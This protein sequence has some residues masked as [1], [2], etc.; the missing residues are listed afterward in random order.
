MLPAYQGNRSAA[1]ELSLEG[2]PVYEKLDEFMKSRDKW[3]GTA[4]AL[5]KELTELASEKLKESDV[6]PKTPKALSNALR[7]LANGMRTMGID[8]DF[9]R[10][11]G[12]KRTRL[13]KIENTHKS[14]SQTSHASQTP[15][16][17]DSE[18]DASGTI[19]TVQGRS[20]DGMP[21]EN[22]EKN[23]IGDDGDS[24]DGERPLLSDD[25]DQKPKSGHD[26]ALEV[27]VL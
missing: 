5:L 22:R 24:R 16:S 10:Q 3:D 17:R 12:G 23:A 4:T 25:S 7:R 13:I 26:D 27:G 1:V 2:S 6:W 21:T 20:R 15:G 9:D 14:S 19:G 11:S 8:V 18:R